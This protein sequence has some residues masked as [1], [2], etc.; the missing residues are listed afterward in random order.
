MENKLNI[1]ISQ[2]VFIRFGNFIFPADYTMAGKKVNQVK[3]I[4]D[5]ELI[6]NEGL[7]LKT[8]VESH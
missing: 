6:I 7:P 8:I 1:N 5:L 4:Q 2:T 3:E